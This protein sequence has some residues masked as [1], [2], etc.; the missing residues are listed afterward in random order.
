LKLG[1]IKESFPNP[2]DTVLK[3]ITAD[4]SLFMPHSYVLLSTDGYMVGQQY[5]CGTG[6]FF[7]MASFPSYVNAGGTALL[8]SRQGVVVDQMP[9]SEKMHYPLLKE[10]KGVALERV[11]WDAPSDQSDN[12]H[13][14]VEAV[15][16]GTPG[17]GNSMMAMHHNVPEEEVI[18]V[19]PKAFSPDG[20]G[21]DDN[22]LV[23]YAFEE[24]GCTMNVYVFNVEGQLIRHLVKGELISQAG[25]FVWNGLDERGQR[26][27]IGLYVMV[28]EVF[29]LNGMV[30]K[31]KQAVVVA[32]R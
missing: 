23:N 21:M 7:D 4:M 20:D 2:A 31:Y 10:T 6:N 19:E 18:K 22:C 5:G 1:V 28:A 30:K 14:A 3:E 13:S 12:W 11:S 24:A 8:M 17:Y 29:H 27:P 9:F 16:F 32:S 15:H 25:S 26:V